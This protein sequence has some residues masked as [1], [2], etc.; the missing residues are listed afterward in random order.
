MYFFL[1]GGAHLHTMDFNG[2]ISSE[3]TEVSKL[4]Y[5]LPVHPH[6][7]SIITNDDGENI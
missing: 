1:S 4:K 6:V 7:E 2:V 3:E 5:F